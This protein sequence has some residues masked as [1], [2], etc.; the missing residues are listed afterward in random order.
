M[1]SVTYVTPGGSS[2]SAQVCV[3]LADVND[4]PSRFTERYFLL[5]N[6]VLEIVLRICYNKPVKVPHMLV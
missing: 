2:L 4:D 1:F 3:T 6:I 5:E